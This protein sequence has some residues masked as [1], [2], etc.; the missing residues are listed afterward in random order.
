LYLCMYLSISVCICIWIC[1]FIC[2]FVPLIMYFFM[3]YHPVFICSARFFHIYS[4]AIMYEIHWTCF[5]H[6]Y[7]KTN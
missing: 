5:I 6:T 2:I 7:M 4:L 3:Y 1:I